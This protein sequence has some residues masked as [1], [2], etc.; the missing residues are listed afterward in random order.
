M[1]YRSEVIIGIPK[2]K[3]QQFIDLQME[4]P[5][6]PVL[7]ILEQV[8]TTE[9]DVVI[10]KGDYLKWYSGYKDVDLINNFVQQCWEKFEDKTFMVAVG[11]D[12]CVHST[13]GEYYDFVNVY[14]AIDIY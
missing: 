1:G 3:A 5:L 10:F 12:G 7:E 11:E 14:T 6:S 9:D 2:E 8:K 13:I 4:A